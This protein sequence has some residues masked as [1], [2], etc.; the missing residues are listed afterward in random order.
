MQPVLVVDGTKEMFSI[1]FIED[2]PSSKHQSSFIHLIFVSD[3]SA[4]NV[5]KINLLLSLHCGTGLVLWYIVQ[6]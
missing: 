1:L 4:E 5:L 3:F 6:V 2:N